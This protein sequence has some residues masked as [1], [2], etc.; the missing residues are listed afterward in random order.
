MLD[1]GV[2]QHS[3]TLR[4]KKTETLPQSY[5]SQADLLGSVLKADQLLGTI[6]LPESRNT[7]HFGSPSEP[8]HPPQSS[9][10][11]ARKSDLK[12]K[13]RESVY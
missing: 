7:P 12:F 2:K 10:A 11:Q 3:T 4:T 6:D 5:K 8:D 1:E 9:P 13:Y